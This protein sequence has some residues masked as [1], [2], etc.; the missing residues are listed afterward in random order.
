VRIPCVTSPSWTPRCETIR[1]PRK[2]VKSTFGFSFGLTHNAEQAALQAAAESYAGNAI[3]A[4][5]IQVGQALRGAVEDVAQ[6]RSIDPT[7]LLATVILAKAAKSKPVDGA[8]KPFS[9]ATKKAIL[10]ANRQRNGG[11]LRSD[12]SGELL[13]PSQKSQSGVTPPSN[14]AQVD[15]I[16]PKSRGGANVPSN[17]QV[18]SRK[19]NRDK[20]DSMP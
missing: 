3:A 19:E 6:G 12:K 5:N 18:L 2:R 17:G 15:H 11:V 20:S 13:V 1:C 10:E 8:G 4:Y 7:A 16:V 9:R 14:E